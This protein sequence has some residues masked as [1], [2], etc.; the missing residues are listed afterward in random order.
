MNKNLEGGKIKNRRATL[1]IE[2]IITDIYIN[3]DSIV[4]EKFILKKKCTIK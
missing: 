2:K 4:K 3:I 1:F